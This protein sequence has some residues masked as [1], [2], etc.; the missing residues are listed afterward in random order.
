MVTGK[1]TVLFLTAAMFAIT[2]DAQELGDNKVVVSGSIQSDILIPQD[3][4]KIGTE[5]TNDW[6]LTNTYAD[7]SLTSDHV[8]AGVRLEYLEHP[9]PGFENDFKVCGAKVVHRTD[10]NYETAVSD[11]VSC[12]KELMSAKPAQVKRIS[13]AAIETS[14]K[15]TWE[16]FIEYYRAAYDI[17]LKNKQKQKQ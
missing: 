3:D 10:S 12:T 7:V 17:A 1:K 8:D 6:G 13:G 15:S 2:M 5:E 11:I 4:K 9:L 16:Q 14:K